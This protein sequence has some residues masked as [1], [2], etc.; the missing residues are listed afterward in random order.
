MKR[1]EK[2]HPI[3]KLNLKGKRICIVGL[4]GSGKSYLSKYLLQ[5]FRRVFIIDPMD[6]YQIIDRD[7]NRVRIVIKDET[8]PDVVYET[9]E[10]TN[11][12][13]LVVDEISRFAPSRKAQ[14]KRLRDYADACRHL[15]TTFM[16]IA[17][18]AGQV[19]TDYVELAHYMF[20]FRLR[21]K[22]DGIWLANQ[23]EGLPSTVHG[24]NQYEFVCLYPDRTYEVFP[25]VKI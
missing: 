6:E 7:R 5:N 17:R 10:N 4:Q 9:I 11:L 13:L 14:N 22:N 19:F 2:K 15:G 25:P 1:R 20:I 8:I 18:R 3:D 21:G 16:G 23:A 24:L 12:D